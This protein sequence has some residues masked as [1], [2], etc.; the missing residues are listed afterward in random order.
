[1]ER[2]FSNWLQTGDQQQIQFDILPENEPQQPGAP[3]VEQNVKLKVVTQEYK[4]DTGNI[5]SYPKVLYLENLLWLLKRD[6]VL[7]DHFVF[8]SD[9]EEENLDEKIFG[10]RL[11]D[12]I[13]EKPAAKY[14]TK[15]TSKS[16]KRVDFGNIG[17]L[18][19]LSRK[20]R[21]LRGMRT[22]KFRVDDIYKQM[23]LILADII[24]D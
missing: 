15:T 10:H 5:L 13:C 8:R 7:T 16:R 3:Y 20:N 24:F 9:S 17:A 1:M 22:P 2:R 11:T 19:E 23:V 12:F 18:I 6:H 21:F 4:N 14:S